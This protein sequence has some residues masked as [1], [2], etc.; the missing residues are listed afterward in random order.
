MTDS[1]YGTVSESNGAEHP[2]VGIFPY[3]AFSIQVV[4]V[5]IFY[6]ANID[7]GLTDRF[8]GTDS[9]GLN[10][11]AAHVEG[12]HQYKFY[13]GVAVMLF[14]GFGF[15]MAFL[16]AYGLGAVGFTMFIQCVAV[17]VSLIL[18]GYI[19]HG[20]LGISFESI[21]HGEFAAA[22]LLITFGA[23]I[24]K[25]NPTQIVVLVPIEVLFYTL[26]KTF[27][28]SKFDVIDIG[29]SIQ[30]HAFG[31]YFGLM[32]ATVLGAPSKDQLKLN[33]S[34][35]VSDLFSLIGTVFLWLF[36]PSFVACDLP[37]GP[38]QRVA[39][40]NTV[41]ALL[42]SAVITFALTPMLQSERKIDPIPIQNA[43]LAGGVAIGSTAHVVG[44]FGAM[45]I[46]LIAGVVS[47]VGF[48]KKPLFSPVD[49]CG[50]HNLHGMPGVLG[51]LVTLV[52]PLFYNVP[53][54]KWQIQILGLAGTLVV[55][56]ATGAITGFVLKM[57]GSPH[58]MFNDEAYWEVADD[59]P[60]KPKEA[61]L[62]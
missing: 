8:T 17:E 23:L 49:V 31:A 56:S 39:I 10:E 50:I 57:L 9:E 4:I 7:P 19:A 35:Y 25:I 13:L 18:E 33:G 11:L 41:L 24:G 1:A 54:L 48:M 44:P 37:D 53:N 5:A 34:S 2:G 32:C 46:G 30:I 59:I 26:N 21:L 38:E 45:V 60:N 27:V 47:T 3:I 58:E 52:L 36:W 16:K 61:L 29:G 22:A 40:L 20:E 62:G 15:L 12:L 55:A 28:M 42:S 6:T 51:G 14:V 43:T